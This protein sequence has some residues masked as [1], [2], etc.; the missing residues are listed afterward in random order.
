MPSLSLE[1][2]GL[3]AFLA[4]AFCINAAPF[5]NDRSGGLKCC[6]PSEDGGAELRLSFSI[7]L[8]AKVL[9]LN[10]ALANTPR[11]DL[12]V[13][14]ELSTDSGMEVTVLLLD[15]LC[16]PAPLGVSENERGLSNLDEE[17]DELGGVAN[18]AE[19]GE[20]Q[21]PP[22]RNDGHQPCF[23]ATHTAETSIRR[24]SSSYTVK[25]LR[26]AF[27]TY[28]SLSPSNDVRDDTGGYSS[29]ELLTGL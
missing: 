26:S 16:L 23:S 19:V 20:Q 4:A 28:E 14:V 25:T 3:P 5:E 8:A 2:A 7:S 18:F 22:Y 13:P 29:S 12:A 9:A 27:A 21:S 11:R 1:L 10:V 6:I 15:R 24:R 17:V